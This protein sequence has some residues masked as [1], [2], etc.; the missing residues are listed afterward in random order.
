MK[1]SI[2]LREDWLTTE[3]Q[4]NFLHIQSE[5][6][7]G[8]KRAKPVTTEFAGHRNVS[9]HFVI[10]VKASED[11]MGVLREHLNE[12]G[13]GILDDAGDNQLHIVL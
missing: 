1:T 11:W 5:L 9:L 4:D 7:E 6:E 2:E 10:E 3:D 12:L 8:I 13:Y